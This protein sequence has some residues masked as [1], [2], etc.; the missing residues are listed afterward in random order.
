MKQFI[1]LFRKDLTE[2]YRTKKIL[3][4]AA[5]FIIFA[6]LSPILAKMTPELLKSIGN[7][8]MQIN[9]PDATIA[10]SYGQFIKNI[11]QLGLFTLIIALGGLVVNERRKGL[12]TNLNNNG[13]KK[14]NFILSKVKSQILIFTMIYAVSAVLFSA[15]IYVIINQFAIAYSFL[16]FLS[17]YVY[18]V[19]VIC[20]VNLFS[21]ISKSTV[22]SI[23]LGIATVLAISIFDLFTF[24]KYLPNYL[25][26]I[27]SNIFSD[28]SCLNYV[29]Q[30]IGITLAI[31]VILAIASIKM[32]SNKE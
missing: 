10:D 30:N 14:H 13:V 25:A 32:C 16:S 20:L 7:E 5:I 21:T 18:L 6:L 2:L 31:S 4:I 8:V 17:L 11:G 27:A 15:Y 3:I 12:Y 1:I 26:T 22:M 19:F 29:Y 23:L 28:T 9:I 24:G